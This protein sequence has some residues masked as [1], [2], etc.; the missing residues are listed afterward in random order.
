M[1]NL[2]TPPKNNSPVSS[3]EGSLSKW[4]G[5]LDHAKN[6]IIGLILLILVVFAIIYTSIIY[7]FM[8]IYYPG[9]VGLMTPR[10]IWTALVPFM[11]AI[12]G[13]LIGKSIS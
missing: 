4:W 5:T 11:L 8:M 6:N 9:T 10:E 7:S 2:I 3:G 12:F 13:V 1:T